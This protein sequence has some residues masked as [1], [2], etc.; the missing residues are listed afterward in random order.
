V[1]VQLHARD[2]GKLSAAR[3]QVQKRRLL[4]L[5]CYLLVLQQATKNSGH[6]T[7]TTSKIMSGFRFLQRKTGFYAA[8]A[9]YWRC[10]SL[11]HALPHISG[12][13]TGKF[14]KGASSRGDDIEMRPPSGAA[15]RAEPDS[16]IRWL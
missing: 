3:T 14:C 7:M 11:Q 16:L 1:S 10:N 12:A 4:Y 8:I 9:G 15:Y 2:F 13:A 5:V 6:Q